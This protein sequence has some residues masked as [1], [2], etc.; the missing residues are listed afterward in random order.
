MTAWDQFIFLQ[1]I[2]SISNL[3]YIVLFVRASTV[4][5]EKKNADNW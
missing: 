2:A 1:N 4:K 5:D 3:L